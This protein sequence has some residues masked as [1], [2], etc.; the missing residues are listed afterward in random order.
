M[1]SASLVNQFIEFN[2]NV[3]LGKPVIKGTRITV[4]LILEKLAA[5]ESFEEILVE[6]PRL[7]R[8][9][10]LAV[11]Q[12]AARAVKLHCPSKSEFASSHFTA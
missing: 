3:L 11:L 4:E 2:S 12:F 9:E 7:K 6:H 10:I 5:G 8:E 1:Q